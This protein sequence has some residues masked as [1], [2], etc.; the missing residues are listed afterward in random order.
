MV[1]VSSTSEIRLRERETLLRLAKAGE[2]RDEDTGNHVIRM[3]KYSRIIAEAMGMSQEEANVIELAAPMHDIGKIGVPSDL[4]MRPGRLNAKERRLVER[5][6][7]I[8]ARLVEPLGIA[9]E[10]SAVIRHH[11]EWWDGSGYPRGQKGRE[12]PLA[13]R[14]LCICDVYDALTS[15][16]VYKAVLEHDVAKAIIINEKG[17]QFDPAVVDAFERGED[18]IVGIRHLYHD[19][20]VGAV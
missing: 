13:A 8:G 12:I 11:H 3:A 15:K 4:L 1:R 16:R 6:P 2:Y 9:T 14:I 17:A 7:E 19:E 5:H 18:E 20:A 10:I